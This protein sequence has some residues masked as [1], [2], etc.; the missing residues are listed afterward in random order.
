MKWLCGN[1]YVN[2]F[3][4]LTTMCHGVGNFSKP[5]I[6]L[7]E[8]KI[9]PILLHA[10]TCPFLHVSLYP[11]L[12]YLIGCVV[13]TMKGLIEHVDYALSKF[14]NLIVTLMFNLSS[15]P[16]LGFPTFSPSDKIDSQSKCSFSSM[17][18]YIL[19]F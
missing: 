8:W 11:P 13:V 4:I 7:L 2:L 16:E 14:G 6:T 3:L 18:M 5:Y 1:I 17:L 15:T 9:T 19:L 12:H 10:W